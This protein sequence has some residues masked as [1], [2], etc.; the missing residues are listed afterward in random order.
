LLR[1][2]RPSALQNLIEL[3][4][5]EVFASPCK[6]LFEQNGCA[7]FLNSA[8]SSALSPTSAD[9][10]SA[11][12]SWIESCVRELVDG[13]CIKAT[14]V[15]EILKL[16]VVGV[17]LKKDVILFLKKL[18]NDRILI[19]LTPWFV[20]V[21][22]DALKQFDAFVEKTSVLMWQY[23]SMNPSLQSVLLHLAAC[24]YFIPI[25]KLL[26]IVQVCSGMFAL[27]NMEFICVHSHGN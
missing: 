24:P 19:R 11:S 7:S 18:I 26:S 22:I 23:D 14:I 20:F 16:I 13:K 10:D 25:H 9:S 5:A 21:D 2:F 8:L 17:T 1:A 4:G 12:L 6:S 3:H 15:R 27:K